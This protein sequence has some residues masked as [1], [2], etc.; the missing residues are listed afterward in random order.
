MRSVAFGWVLSLGLSGAA[1]AQDS[2]AE[3]ARVRI[4]YTGGSG[5]VGSAKYNFES[6]RALDAMKGSHGLQLQEVHAI[7]GVLVS[8]EIALWAED[9]SVEAAVRFLSSTDITCE[10]APSV[11][12]LRTGPELLITEQRSEERRVGKEC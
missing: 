6:L 9:R 1:R 10:G 8:G 12:A 3:P 11:W 5:G 2:A 7:H 4:V